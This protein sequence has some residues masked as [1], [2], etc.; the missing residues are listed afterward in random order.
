VSILPKYSEFLKR[1]ILYAFRP[2]TII[3]GWLARFQFRFAV[4]SH[5]QVS[6]SQLQVSC[7]QLQVSCSQLHVSC[8]QFA[9]RSFLNLF[10]YVLEPEIAFNH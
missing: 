6:C 9:F 4:S 2:S 10:M 3:R 1:N 5:L 8:S 7:S